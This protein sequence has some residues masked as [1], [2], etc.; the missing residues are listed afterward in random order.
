M[1]AVKKGGN[2]QELHEVI[3]VCS[4]DATK[5]MKEGE[6]WD[7][8][9]ALADNKALGLTIGETQRLLEPNLFIGRCVSQVERFVKNAKAIIGEVDGESASINL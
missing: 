6:P 1:E 4:M 2:R 3:R 7:L 5:K 9:Q 8:L